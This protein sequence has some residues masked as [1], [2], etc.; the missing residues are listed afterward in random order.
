MEAIESDS[1]SAWE[2]FWSNHGFV[3]VVSQSTDTRADELQRRIILSQ[4]LLRVNEAGDTPP[5]EVRP[6][7]PAHMLWR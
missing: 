6:P 1:E 7:L 3:D 5:Q 4:Y 2:D